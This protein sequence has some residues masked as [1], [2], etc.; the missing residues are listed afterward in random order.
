MD[1]EDIGW[2][3]LLVEADGSIEIRAFGIRPEVVGCGYGGAFLTELV[4]HAWLMGADS[5]APDAGASRRVWLRTSSWDHPHAVAN[6]LAR[7]FSVTHRELQQKR[8][9]SDEG[10]ATTVEQPPEVLVRP[11]VPQDAPDVVTLLS[12]LGYHRPVE[13]VEERLRRLSS[14]PDDVPVAAI[15]GGQRVAGILVCHIVP[16]LAEDEPALLRITALSVAPGQAR[17][18]L[19]RRL[20][21]FAEY[22]AWL[23]GCRLLEVS[24]GRRPEREAAHLFYPALGFE[25]STKTSIRYWKR[26]QVTPAAKPPTHPG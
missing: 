25:D 17:R 24:S 7:G 26:S 1:G 6:Y 13:V 12:D 5:D 2:A 11:A 3:S 4:R 21:E 16:L 22:F 8:G 10:P 23:R 9:G 19:G 18:G 20:V 15:V 14:S